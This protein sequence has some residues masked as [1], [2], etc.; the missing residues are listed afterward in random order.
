MYKCEQCQN[1]FFDQDGAANHA[2]KGAVTPDPTPTEK[3]AAAMGGGQLHRPGE[4]MEP[5]DPPEL[6]GGLVPRPS[7]GRIVHYY[8]REEE[9][10]QWACNESEVLPAI[11]T[12]V[13]PACVNLKVFANGGN[14]DWAVTSVLEGT[15]RGMYAWPAHV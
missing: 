15:A 11:I 13:W 2:C 3:A 7:V 12:K 5:F 9:C 4:P 8:P 14:Q 1:L 10:R 6:R